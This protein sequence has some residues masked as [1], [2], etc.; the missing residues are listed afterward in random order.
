MSNSSVLIASGSIS[1]STKD[2]AL[3]RDTFPRV[4][5]AKG[6]VTPTI[7]TMQARSVTNLDRTAYKY[8]NISNYSSRNQPQCMY[9]RDQEFRTSQNELIPKTKMNVSAGELLGRTHEEL[10]LL[11]IQLR[12]QQAQTF[13]AIESC[14]NEIDSL[15]IHIHNVDQM[16]RMENL[17]KL[18][19]IKQNLLELEKQYEK[20]KPLVNLVD[21][22]VKLGSLYRNPNERTDIARHIREKLEFNQ[23]VQERRL[24]ADEKRDWN[25]IEPSHVQLQQKVRQLYQLDGLIQEESRNLH[26]LQ[27]DKEDIER[28]LGGLRN[29]LLKGLNNPEEIEQARRQQFM[30]E[31]ELSRVHLMLAQ[32]SKKLEETV[33]G[34][35]RLEQERLKDENQSSSVSAGFRGMIPGAMPYLAD[36]LMGLHFKN[37]EVI[38]IRRDVIKFVI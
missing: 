14:Y 12:R 24:L 3:G 5:N 6:C 8:D 19:R 28:A 9:E 17:H 37:I 2:A 16:K 1:I 33:A 38:N 26:N 18:E 31:N 4:V 10:V 20:R 11:L 27:R 32:N 22:M 30:L 21:N 29:R 36:K 25:R 34:N 13:Q 15:Q 23:Y 35:A 7:Q